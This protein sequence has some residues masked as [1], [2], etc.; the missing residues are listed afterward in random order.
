MRSTWTKALSLLL[1][2]VMCLSLLP[3]YALA[4]ELEEEELLPAAEEVI[5]GEDGDE[6]E[7]PEGGAEALPAAAAAEDEGSGEDDPAPEE[8]IVD[9]TDGEAAGPVGGLDGALTGALAEDEGEDDPE[10]AEGEAETDPEEEEPTRDLEDGEDGEGEEPQE[11]SWADV[12]ASA[13][14]LTP[15]VRVTAVIGDDALLYDGKYYTFFSFTPGESRSYSFRSYSDGEQDTWCALY[16]SSGTRL[17]YDDDD[18]GNNDFNVTY[19]FTAGATYYFG[20]RLY[21]GGKG[22]SFPVQLNPYNNLS[23]RPE[24]YDPYI[25]AYDGSVQLKVTVSA[26]ETDGLTYRWY[27]AE[28]YGNWPDDPIQGADGPTY[29]VSSA[30][31]NCYYICYVTDKYGDTGFA[32]FEV[33]VDN[34]LPDE[35]LEFTRYVES[36]DSVLLESPFEEMVQHGSL[37]YEWTRDYGDVVGTDSAYLAENITE[38]TRYICQVYDECGNNAGAEFHVYINSGLTAEAVGETNRTVH[39]GEEVTLTVTASVEQ[40]GLTYYWNTGEETS[41]VT[42]TVGPD[43]GGWYVCHV[44][45]DYGRDVMVDFYIS[46]YTGFYA[47]RITP[48]RITG[49]YNEPVTLQID[50]GVEYGE[51]HVSWTDYSADETYETNSTEFTT[52][53]IT[54]P[55]DF[56]CYVWDDY[57]HEDYYSF[58]IVLENNLE[59]N[60]SGDAERYVEPG[61]TVTLTVQVSADDMTGISYQW[62]RWSSDSGNEMVGT[63]SPTFTTDPIYGSVEYGCQVTDRYGMVEWAWVTVGIENHLLVRA[64]G[65]TERSVP[66]GE[67]AEL[68]V[69]ATADDMTGLTYQ[70]YRW[71]PYGENEK[72]GTNSPTYTTEPV[73]ENTEYFCEVTDCYGTTENVW[74]RLRLRSMVTV[75]RVSPDSCM[76]SR[77]ESVTL[78]VSVTPEDADFT[79]RWYKQTRDPVT[80]YYSDSLISGATGTSYTIASVT[81]YASYECLVTDSS[82]VSE[83]VWFN[84]GVENHLEV[85]ISG[86]NE[87]FVEAGQTA[88]LTVQVSA[89]DMTGITYQWY[90]WSNDGEDV[91]VGTNS[92]TYT[93]G[94]V[95]GYAEYYCEVTDQY[96]GYESAWF[97]VGIDNN[98]RV[99]PVGGN[100]HFGATGEQLTL[101]VVVTANDMEGITYQWLKE[102][103]DSVNGYRVENIPGATGPTLLTDPIDGYVQYGCRVTDKFGTEE[104]AWISVGI[105]NH[106]RVRAV[107]G[108]EYNVSP[109]ETVDLAVSVTADD[110]TDLTYQWY[111]WSRYGENE[112]VGE[113]WRGCESRNQQPH[114]HYRADNG[115]YR[116]FLRS[117]RLLRHN[118]NRLVP[119]AH[120]KQHYCDQSRG[121]PASGLQRQHRH[122]AGEGPGA[123]HERDPVS[124]VQMDAGG[125]RNHHPRRHKGHVYHRQ[126]LF[127]N[128]VLLP[129]HRQQRQRA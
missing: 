24:S 6:E 43:T 29:T 94:P 50:A 19:N 7:A 4:A 96:G 97:R 2:I 5:A 95:T 82:N 17:T 46:I 32:S 122:P 91:K 3:S 126:G 90:R 87:R 78:E 57:G 114:L 34:G 93:T 128:G 76:V 55:S 39:P 41:S 26:N 56:R 124:V 44:R 125:R 110:M 45:D 64:V 102:Y 47:E 105:E 11:A 25:V 21:G 112:K 59:V 118:E 60:I 73:T 65:S 79:C 115:I 36:G 116:V 101:E 71:S 88:T 42:F 37:R 69:S 81:E 10:P 108:N 68:A 107:D 99:T 84:V 27:Q 72:V 70:W 61:E 67:T 75:E 89:D 111:R 66:S 16:N 121:L 113:R 58:Q 63:N 119:C 20:A 123:Q 53:P 100:D 92:P 104:W 117:D 35:W 12:T 18:G 54:A 48:Y 83:Y 31:H 38:Y 14:P 9:E 74:F 62:Y 77:G 23:V 28:Q 106:L 98:L 49:T 129:G 33:L 85:Y 8:I 40:G 109:G 52:G 103:Y 127:C 120:R 80:G 86:N 22:S 15:G 51:L 13:V 30:V 1:S